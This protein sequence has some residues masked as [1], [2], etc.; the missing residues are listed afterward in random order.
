MC[1]EARYKVNATNKISIF[2]INFF[3]V[4]IITRFAIIIKYVGTTNFLL[5]AE[6]TVNSDVVL[7]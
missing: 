2:K 7:A 6:H 3:T 4:Y 5:H 1:C